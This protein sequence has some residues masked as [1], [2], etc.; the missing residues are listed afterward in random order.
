M[1][2]NILHVQFLIK[3]NVSKSKIGFQS[4]DSRDRE[5]LTVKYLL[6]LEVVRFCQIIALEFQSGIETLQVLQILCQR[7]GV[8]GRKDKSRLLAPQRVPQ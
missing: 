4:I 7:V 6:H 1:L 3:H 8:G 2:Q 5:T